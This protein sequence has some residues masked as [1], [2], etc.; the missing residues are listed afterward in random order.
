[1]E[2]LGV[3]YFPLYPI[4]MTLHLFKTRLRI[5]EGQK[6]H[7]TLAMLFFFFKAKNMFSLPSYAS[8]IDKSL[9]GLSEHW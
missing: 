1:M 7:I 8:E 2:H 6:P 4:Q 9:L 5:R 3:S